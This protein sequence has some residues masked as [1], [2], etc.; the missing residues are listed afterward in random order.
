MP[1][2][3]R[4]EEAVEAY[5]A[6]GGVDHDDGA[7]APLFQSVDR[8][9]RLSGRALTRRAVLAMI[10]RRAAAA[11]LPASTCCHTFRATGITAYLSNGGTL[12]HAQRIAG[13]AS[14]K[15]TN[16]LG[17]GNRASPHAT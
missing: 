17:R 2:H 8:A 14:P 7:K 13:H 4:A 9:G 6:A 12:E 1:A 10:K 3:H 5:L 16:P 15:T 11:G